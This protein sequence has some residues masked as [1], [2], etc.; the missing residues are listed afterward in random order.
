MGFNLINVN[1][2]RAELVMHAAASGGSLSFNVGKKVTQGTFAR[3]I[4]FAS[5]ADREAIGQ[6]MYAKWLQNNTYRP[7]V[8]DILDCGLVPKAALPYVRVYSGV[9]EAGPVSREALVKLC[10]AVK[11]EVDSKVA[12][13]KSIPKGQKG[14]VY[15]VVARI[16]EAADQPET[17]D[18]ETVNR[19]AAPQ[20]E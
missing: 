13:G 20:S 16:A 4:A 8:N 2:E 7:V 12:A 10:I 6:A 5:K 15:G 1:T 19:D 9:T 18:A 14:F 11:A 17:V 3:A